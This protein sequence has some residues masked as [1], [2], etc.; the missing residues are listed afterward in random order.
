MSVV[1]ASVFLLFALIFLGFYIGKRKIV[2]QDAAP[3]L[4][5]LVLKVTMPVTVFCSIVEQQGQ[6][7][8]GSAWQI[9]FGVLILHIVSFLASLIL[10][11]L[12]RIPPK[13]Q[14]PWLFSLIFSNNGFMGLPLSLAVF[15]TRGL[16]LMALGNVFSN[17]L[18]FSLGVKILTRYYET[19]E[20]ISFRDMFVNNINIA[21]LLGFLFLLLKIPLPDIADRLLTY[22]SN[23]TSGLSML[24]VGI[25]LSRL[26]FR[27]VFRDRKMFLLPLFRLIVFPMAVIGILHVLPLQMNPEIR[28][29]LILVSCLPAASAQSMITEQYHTNTAG[30]ARAVF[31][32]TLFSVVT[33][34]V[35]MA[36]AGV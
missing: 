8:V 11:R 2:R 24:V 16:F 14:G 13:E 5:N 22:L 1:A 29:I 18:L 33:V 9:V 12:L 27:A 28:S 3:D 36:A 30:A 35:I 23:I 34:P 10:V 6:E 7:G 4:S 31:I 21:V 20:K 25:S 15:G 32:T 26:P 19:D 17:L